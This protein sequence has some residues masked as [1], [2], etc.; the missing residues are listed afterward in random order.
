VESNGVK[1]GIVKCIIYYLLGMLMQS[2][3]LYGA[4][5]DVEQKKLT[6]ADCFVLKKLWVPR[7]EQISCPRII[8]PF[9][10][11]KQATVLRTIGVAE[12]KFLA[13]SGSYHYREIQGWIGFLEG[14]DKSFLQ[15]VSDRLLACLP[16]KKYADQ[17]MDGKEVIAAVSDECSRSFC[18][19]TRTPATLKVSLRFYDADFDASV[20]APQS[21]HEICEYYHLDINDPRH[22]E[23]LIVSVS[24]KPNRSLKLPYLTI[25]V[26]REHAYLRQ[27]RN[28]ERCD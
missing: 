23:F 13:K 8:M 28:G 21:L 14:D 17:A 19:K 3:L 5:T 9:H 2:L 26:E 10:K 7:M 20:I 11:V 6:F 15:Q 16:L 24:H 1:K 25:D 12:K 4:A 18:M 22:R 27:E